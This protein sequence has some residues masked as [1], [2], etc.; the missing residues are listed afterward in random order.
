MDERCLA[1]SRA[2]GP[3]VPIDA[4]REMC[5]FKLPQSWLQAGDT[6]KVMHRDFPSQKK[7][8]TKGHSGLT[9]PYPRKKFP[10]FGPNWYGRKYQKRKITPIGGLFI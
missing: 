9:L 2:V 3:Y 8:G 4:V 1:L 5:G 10:R 7:K 6:K